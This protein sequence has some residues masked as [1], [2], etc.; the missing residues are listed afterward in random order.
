MKSN[1]TSYLLYIIYISA[2]VLLN[3]IS[4]N[5]FKRLDLTDN[6]MY[7]LSGSS[8]STID[9]IDDPLIID[10]YFSDDLPGQ[11]QNNKRYI[12]DI[13]EE[14]AAYSSYINFYFVKNDENFASKAQE[15]GIQSQDI[16]VI[17][18]D[19]VT[20]KTIF[21]GMKLRYNGKSEVLPMLGV[22]AGLEY[23]LT[24]TM[25]KLIAD[26]QHTI[27]IAKAGSKVGSY[28]NINA[29][30]GERFIINNNMPLDNITESEASLVLLGNIEGDLTE[31]ELS[32]LRNFINGG[33]K[34]FLAQGKINTDLKT[35]QGS[36]KQ[37]N[38]YNLLNEYGLN[39]EENL[40]LDKN[41]KKIIATTGGGKGIMSLFNRIQ[42]DYPLI[43][44]ITDFESYD[45]LT[46]GLEGL[47]AI[48]IA[49]PS[50]IIFTDTTNSFTFMPLLKTS[51][52]S[53]TMTD[54]F[55]LGALPEVNPMLNNLTEDAKI[56]AAKLLV[57]GGGEI[58][59]IT[60]S[61][62]FDDNNIAH[63]VMV[64]SDIN[65][66]FTMIENIIDVMLGDSE[67]VALRSRE[68]ISRPF[69]EEA[70]GKE[71]S[72]LRTKWKWINILLPSLLIAAY[73]LVRRRSLNK[74]SKYIMEY[75]G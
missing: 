20:F 41:S 17:E 4:M 29:I 66:N 14:Y 59:L 48:Q 18:N 57:P 74:K 68:I 42:I 69:I 36:V 58:T 30:L 61:E 34:L 23:T 35:W 64:R 56:I 54:F 72:S 39:I 67:L 51:N 13:L 37:S 25:K 6:R 52:N 24:R 32:G 70:Q 63:N 1:K 26:K 28:E 75:Y 60:D 15:D 27:A 44:T 50:E 45:N 46:T 8:K 40:I 71:N 22:S 49:F 2:F 33:G 5:Y 65:E 38:I 3:L 11:L 10:L 53:A 31:N 12:Q 47:Q 62:F 7:S 16:Q 19:E 9:K 43:P 73:G 55:N 21:M